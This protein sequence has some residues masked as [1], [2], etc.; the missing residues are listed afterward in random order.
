MKNP[1]RLSSTWQRIKLESENRVSRAF[2]NTKKKKR[3]REE[4][5]SNLIHQPSE[6]L[7]PLCLVIFALSL[8]IMCPFRVW[9]LQQ[10]LIPS[11][12]FILTDLPPSCWRAQCNFLQGKWSLHNDAV[13][14]TQKKKKEKEERKR[15]KKKK[16]NVANH[17]ILENVECAAVSSEP[18]LLKGGSIVRPFR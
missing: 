15:R 3:E 16:K 6:H 7:H 12:F 14:S 8:E 10:K 1:P 17:S 11:T 4:G 9:R 13:F 18:A 5:K 2:L